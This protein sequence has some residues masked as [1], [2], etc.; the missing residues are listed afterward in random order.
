MRLAPVLPLVLF[1]SGPAAAAD[2]PEWRG[3]NRTGEWTENGLVDRF[4]DSGLKVKWRTPAGSG[5]SGPSVAAGRVYLADFRRTSPNHGV[6][7][8]LCL[9]E[10]SGA[11]LWTAE[12][13]ADYTGLADTY[14]IG[15]RATPTVDAGRVYMLGASGILVCLNARNGSRIWQRDLQKEFGATLPVWGFAAAPLVDGERLLCLAG[16]EPNANVLALD[17][18]TGKEIWR[19]LSGSTEPGYSQPILI[20]AG[21]ARQLIV[22]H[23][24]ALTSLEPAT[25]RV[26]WNQ[27]FR[28]HLNTPVATPVRSGSRLLVSS[29]FNG[30]LMME[31]D[32]ERPAARRLWQGK[33]ASEIDTDGLHALIGTPVIDGDYIYGVCSYGQMRCIRAGNGE[34]V[35]ETLEVTGEKAR[36]AAAFLV[37]NC[38]RYFINN[39]AGE[40]ILAKLSPEGYMELDRTRL[41]EPTSRPGNR[42]RAGAVN[43]VH[44]AYANR[45]LV[46][47]NDREVIRVSLER[48]QQ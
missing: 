26:Y 21:R 4:A 30:S 17:K 2:W 25:G 20:D 38:D 42:R 14:A 39:D 5:F 31:L 3:A 44:P 18:R 29:F 15:P 36:W 27:P 35:W 43:W 10:E 24:T 23:S 1:L 28:P 6:E 22:W 8:V 7:R 32:S 41:I 11:V 19:A 40:L 34:R 46:T 47:R 33:S 16:G 37:R 48:E 9:D 45:H 13:P 12:W